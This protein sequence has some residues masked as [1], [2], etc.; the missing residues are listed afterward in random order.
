MSPPPSKL[1]PT[2]TLILRVL[3]EQHSKSKK[4]KGVQ[5]K[6]LSEKIGV[7]EKA[8][9]TALNMLWDRGLVTQS[10]KVDDKQS[11]WRIR[12][13][14]NQSCCGAPADLH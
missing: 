4:Y 5:V 11:Y 1:D 2:K 13:G 6:L 8:I 9:L 3:T 14:T 7:G 10:Y 12:N